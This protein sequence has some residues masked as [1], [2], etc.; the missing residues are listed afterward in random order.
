MG[1][2]A[3]CIRLLSDPLCNTIA[4]DIPLAADS[5]SVFFS[6]SRDP[7]P[8]Y[9][10]PLTIDNGFSS[11][12]LEFRA[13]H[14]HAGIDLRTF[15]QTGFPV[16]AIGD[17]TVIQIKMAKNDTGKAL[18]LR[19][20]D[21]NLAV[22]YHLDRFSSRLEKIV[23]AVQRAKGKKYF[24][25]YELQPPLPVRRG[26]R[27][28]FS[29]ETGSGFA[30]LHLEIRDPQDRLLDPF[31]L[32]RFPY[33]DRNP[34]L[35]AG[36]LLRSR[37]PALLNGEA[38]ERF[39][40]LQRSNG[41]YALPDTVIACGPFDAVL[42]TQDIA[43]TG[44][45]VAPYAVEA[46]IDGRPY[47][48]LHLDSFNR[49]DN[50]Q[51]GLV[52]DLFHSNGD[53]FYYN[54]FSQPGYELETLKSPLADVWNSL[55]EGNH[56]LD[57]WVSDHFGN[58]ASALIQ[59]RKTAQPEL[60]VN[61]IQA[62]GGLLQARW[63]KLV[64]DAQS[65]VTLNVYSLQGRCG[66]V[67]L[68]G[69]EALRRN[70]M[71]VPCAAGLQPAWAEFLFSLAGQTYFRKKIDLAP[72]AVSGPPDFAFDTYVNRDWLTLRLRDCS[73]PAEAVQ[74]KVVQGDQEQLLAARQ[75]KQGLYF[76]FQPLND[77]SPL[78]LRFRFLREGVAA[79]E[80]EMA[81]PLVV[82]QPQK[83][84]EFRWND[85]AAE[86]ADRS[87]NEPKILVVHREKT[88][89]DYPALSDTV[90]LSPSVFPF[91]DTVFFKF[92][93]PAGLERPEQVGIFRYLL[94]AGRWQYVPTQYEQGVFRTRVLNA[95]TFALLRDIYPPDIRLARLPTLSLRSLKAITVCIRDQGMG[96]DENRLRVLLNGK[97]VDCEY[98][99]DWAHVRVEDLQALVKGLNELQVE[100]VDLAGNL[101]QKVFRFTLH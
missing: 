86:F 20:A 72:T 82:L 14:F 32:L 11:S 73:W 64:C 27:I 57:I 13:G 63:D 78:H 83:A 10:W 54:L 45:R 36:I 68:P 41:R 80:K 87:V 25:D 26:Q 76:C 16:L 79:A 1:R 77:Q 35:L 61:V 60:S 3:I 75:E 101:A 91:L 29:G 99:P 31:P 44:K 71:D 34:P 23:T 4:Y 24:G 69:S 58:T 98:D 39:F 50:H 38:G 6:F 92:T 94:P 74:L 28:A 48:C 7:S 84:G 21:G 96:V 43:D 37:G 56:W 5:A 62:Q 67:T 17:G 47:F 9:A 33:P 53:I 85:F 90:D 8:K 55:A 42:A 46:R 49:D 52:Y 95:G 81:V 100:A 19:L 93:S 89:A 18:Y 2:W 66:S 22:Y 51:V 15:Q 12:F 65:E 40:K 70:G 59:L 88:V 97:P 30:H